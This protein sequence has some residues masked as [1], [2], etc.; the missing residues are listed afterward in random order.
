MGNVVTSYP[1]LGAW[2]SM[3]TSLLHVCVTSLVPVMP[4]FVWHHVTV[5]PCQWPSLLSFHKSRDPNN[6]Q[7]AVQSLTAQLPLASYRTER[8]VCNATADYCLDKIRRCLWCESA[9]ESS[10]KKGFTS[11]LVIRQWQIAMRVFIR[12]L[13]FS[14]VTE[15][16]LVLSDVSE[17]P[18]GRIFEGLMMLLKFATASTLRVEPSLVLRFVPWGQGGQSLKFTAHSI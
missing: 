13:L 7:S 2:I 6:K 9:A 10:P 14:D 3:Q 8:S 15:R 11:C 5:L 12:S 18:I 4:L 1:Q 17:R 16:W